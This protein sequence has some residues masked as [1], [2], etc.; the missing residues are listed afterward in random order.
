[1]S[2]LLEIEAQGRHS[3]SLY[4]V[5]PPPGGTTISSNSVLEEMPQVKRKG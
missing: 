4:R 5:S 3:D 1:M 2:S